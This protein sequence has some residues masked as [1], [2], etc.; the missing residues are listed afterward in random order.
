M[1]QKR[2][3]GIILKR[4]QVMMIVIAVTLFFGIIVGSVMANILNQQQFME[5]TNFSNDFFLSFDVEKLNQMNVFKDCLIKYGKVVMIVWLLGF[6]PIGG[7]FSLFI[8]LMKGIAYGFTTAF[9][10]RA[11]GIEGSFMAILLY[12]MQNIILITAYMFVIYSS[13]FYSVQNNRQARRYGNHFMEY[14]IVLLIGFSSVIL[15]SLIE[16]YVIPF[17]IKIF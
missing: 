5:L 2:K 16:T 10:V 6:I 13:I 4:N 14:S 11:Y 7:I 8:M 3:T 15:G 17:F 9:L 12:F 1:R